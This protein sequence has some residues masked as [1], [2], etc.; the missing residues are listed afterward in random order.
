MWGEHLLNRIWRRKV[1]DVKTTNG[2]WAVQAELR[3]AT[4]VPPHRT[5]RAFTAA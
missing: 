1:L 3:N 5:T 4:A 2:R